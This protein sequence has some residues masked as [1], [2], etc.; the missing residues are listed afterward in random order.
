MMCGTVPCDIIQGDNPYVLNSIQPRRMLIG[1]QHI[2]ESP[3]GGE[4]LINLGSAG[5]QIN[6]LNSGRPLAYGGR[7]SG[8]PYADVFYVGAGSRILHRGNLGGPIMSLDAYP[9]STVR[10]IVMNP[11]NYTQVFVSDDQNRVWGSFDEGASWHDFTANL[12]SLPGQITTIEVFSPDA[13]IRN[14]V[15]IAGGFGIFQ[16]R[17]PGAGGGSWTPLSS[18][19]PNALVMDLHYDYTDDVLVAGTLGRGAWTLTGFFRGGGGTG[20]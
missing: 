11:Q 5:H 4:M 18:G 14:A 3:D 2:Y 10:T 19:F 8:A 6:G 20:R 13:S 12:P 16:M 9:G 15:L 7:L 17:R 1:T